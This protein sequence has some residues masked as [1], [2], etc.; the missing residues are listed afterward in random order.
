[1][2]QVA[3]TA[4]LN[5]Q[6][7]QHG[8]RIPFSG[9]LVPKVLNSKPADELLERIRAQHAALQQPKRRRKARWT[10]TQVA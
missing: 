6:H 10:K 7:R 8:D 1:V 3:T 4:S 2:P 9:E 5:G